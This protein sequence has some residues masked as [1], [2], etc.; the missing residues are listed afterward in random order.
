MVGFFRPVNRVHTLQHQLQVQISEQ[1]VGGSFPKD[2]E[3][4]RE[5]LLSYLDS[6]ISDLQT[7]SALQYWATQAKDLDE[8]F[9]KS[10][11]Q[12]SAYEALNCLARQCSTSQGR[13]FILQCLPKCDPSFDELRKGLFAISDE[14]YKTPP[15]RL[16]WYCSLFGV[17]R[18]GSKFELPLQFELVLRKIY[19]VA[20]V[21]LDMNLMKSMQDNMIN[22]DPELLRQGWGLDCKAVKVA[23]LDEGHKTI[24]FRL[25]YP[26]EYGNNAI[27][28]FMLHVQRHIDQAGKL[29]Y[30]QDTIAN[31]IYDDGAVEVKQEHKKTI[32]RL[33]VIC[34][35]MQHTRDELTVLRDARDTVQ[36]FDFHHGPYTQS[37]TLWEHLLHSIL[38]LLKAWRC[39]PPDLNQAHD[40]YV[41]KY[42]DVMS[43]QLTFK[44][45]TIRFSR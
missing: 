23:G 41:K 44:E 7:K 31:I 26:T 12:A 24:L 18:Q 30:Y 38:L 5:R 3:E 36:Q 1:R 17:Q 14:D 22:T 19:A 13:D 9:D 8:A 4:Q 28:S 27:L 33:R 6:K 39:L 42:R 37:L 21:D 16:A 2:P 10:N 32:D 40:F 15:E 34:E 43:N 25:L 29:E 35:G 11:C 45:S 20:A